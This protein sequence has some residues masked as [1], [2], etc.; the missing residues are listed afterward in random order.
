MGA[1]AHIFYAHFPLPYQLAKA[2]RTFIMIVSDKEGI[3][4]V[5]NKHSFF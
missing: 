2:A 5:K 4:K 3:S 1:S